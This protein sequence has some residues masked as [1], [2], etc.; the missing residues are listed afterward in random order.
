MQRFFVLIVKAI[1]CWENFKQKLVF[2]IVSEQHWIKRIITLQ[3]IK[4]SNAVIKKKVTTYKI[5]LDAFLND[6]N[7]DEKMLGILKPMKNKNILFYSGPGTFISN[8][9]LI[10]N[11]NLDL[12]VE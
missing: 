2:V 5:A 9:I 8:F 7:K 1:D 12:D 11:N 10:N 3:K 6:D 4:K